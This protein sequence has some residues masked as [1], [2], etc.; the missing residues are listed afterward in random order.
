MRRKPFW[1]L[2]AIAVV[3]AATQ[4]RA[5][6]SAQLS[7][8]QYAVMKVDEEFRLAKM[9][10][11]TN[12]LERI[13]SDQFFETNQN[14]NSRNK[15]QMVEL[16]RTFPIHLLTTDD[17][18]VRISDGTAFVTGS[19]TEDGDHMF[20]MRAYAKNRENWQLISSI[21]FHKPVS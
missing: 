11:D 12:V 7:T 13:L 9:R 8:D 10:N 15:G 1:F 20:F 3:F 17:F 4:I 16:F 5:Q 6:F 18:H 19:Q 21:Q 14:K 2:T